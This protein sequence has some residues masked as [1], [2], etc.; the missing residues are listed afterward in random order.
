M[1]VGGLR[2]DESSA[3]GARV[4][5]HL[6]GQSTIDRVTFVLRPNGYEAFRRRLASI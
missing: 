1:P 6:R 3:F 5:G 4:A 2:I